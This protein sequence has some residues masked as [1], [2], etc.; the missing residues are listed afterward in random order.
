MRYK[1]IMIILLVLSYSL[2][3]NAQDSLN[4]K[5]QN[6]IR[7]GYRMLKFNPI[8]AIIDEIPINY[9]F[10][11]TDRK[12]IEIKAG[13]IWP[14]PGLRSFGDAFGTPRFNYLGLLGGGGIRNYSK[15]GNNCFSSYS[16]LIRL[17]THIGSFWTG[18][19][20]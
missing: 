11:L 1:I 13:L 18:G 5:T 15:K 2:C 12:A 4:I 16:L 20:S 8:R 6:S 17:K 14:N 19:K 10:P 9:E 3:V 7:L